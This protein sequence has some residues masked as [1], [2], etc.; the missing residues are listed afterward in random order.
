MVEWLGE[1]LIHLSSPHEWQAAVAAHFPSVT[2]EQ[3]LLRC[4]SI[5]MGHR[6]LSNVTS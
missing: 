1:L 4:A 3:T 2:V 6:G 5:S